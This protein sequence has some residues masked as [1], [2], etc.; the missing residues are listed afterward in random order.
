MP[1]RGRRAPRR[2]RP[3]R[4]APRVRRIRRPRPAAATAS[5]ST[6]TRTAGD[7][8]APALWPAIVERECAVLEVSVE[9]PIRLPLTRALTFSP[10]APAAPDRVPRS[11]PEG[12][13]L[14]LRSVA[15]LFSRVWNRRFYP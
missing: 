5:A 6:S 14:M 10:S 7:A 3:R 4:P 9:V 1:A 2:R 12:K 13:M 11:N 15:L 8:E